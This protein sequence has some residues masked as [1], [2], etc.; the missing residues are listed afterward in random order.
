[1]GDVKVQQR[2]QGVTTSVV[3][4]CVFLVLTAFTWRSGWQSPS[5]ASPSATG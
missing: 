1:M 4:C 2:C 5:T 3:L